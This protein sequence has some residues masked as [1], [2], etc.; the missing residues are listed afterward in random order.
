MIVKA[1]IQPLEELSIAHGLWCVVRWRW[2]FVGCL[3][4][5]TGVGAVLS[6]LP[7]RFEYST[8]L[9]VGTAV[10]TS[11]DGS[12][13]RR[14]PLESSA[15]VAQKI[16]AV[17]GPQQEVERQVKLTARA[18]G[19][20]LV[21][22]S[23]RAELADE[24]K[25]M[26][27]HARIAAALTQDQDRFYSGERASQTTIIG[28]SQRSAHPISQSPLVMT[29]LGVCAGGFAGIVAVFMAQAASRVAYVWRMSP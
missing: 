7:Q 12:S 5:G 4:L 18:V 13:Q 17:Y 22:M 3:L 11:A 27:A 6:L 16:L 21:V 20:D 15:T 29:L 10:F 23:S 9:Q 25:H 8:A 14:V 1:A 28:S 26:E 2:L 24:I 19:D